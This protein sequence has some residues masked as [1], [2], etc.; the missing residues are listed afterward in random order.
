MAWAALTEADVL[1]VMSGPE[2]EGIRAAAL[3]AGQ[4]DPVAPT[5]V[6]VT[7]LVRGYIAVSSSLGADGTLPSKLQTT[8]LDIIASRIPQRV[9]RN[10]S[11]G[12]RDK[13]KEAIR[14]LER[15][16][17]GKFRVEEPT[18]KSEEST[19]SVTP[20]ISAPKRRFTRD[21]QDGI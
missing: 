6:D 12:R 2:L 14:L 10:P 20:V 15:V 5:I 18:T 13:E 7:D 19:G 4:A 3:R 8:A 1:T 11:Q 16:A 9:N 21:S 17:D